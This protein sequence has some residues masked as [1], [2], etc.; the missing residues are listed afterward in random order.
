MKKQEFS[1]INPNAPYI[2]GLDDYELPAEIKLDPR[3]MKRNPYAGRVKFAHGG[4]RRGAGRKRLAE[5]LE[6]HTITLYKSQTKFLRGLDRNLSAAIR[7][8]IA[9]AE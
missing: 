2:P 7:K 1:K 4:V 6:R 5:P 8:L 3:K 9:Q